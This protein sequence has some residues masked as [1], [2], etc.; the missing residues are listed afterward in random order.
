VALARKLLIRPNNRVLALNAPP[1][2]G[3]L[4]GPLP[5][6]AVISD[7]LQPEAYDVVHLFV[8][9]QAEL[10]RLAPDALRSAKAGAVIWISY[11]KQAAKV[12]TDITRDRGWDAITKEGWRPVTQV[13]V[14]DVWSA[15]RWRSD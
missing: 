6:G 12:P 5:E 11:P 13:S 4:T 10:A 3:E 1:N 15:L 8:E 9:S 2:Y 14:D 7:R